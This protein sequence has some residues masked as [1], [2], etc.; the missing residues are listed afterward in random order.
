MLKQNI[1]FIENKAGSLQKATDI[2]KKEQIQIFGF[3]CFDA[4]E[5][6]LFR[7]VCSDAEKA[8]K[9]LSEN[10]YM[11]RISR[12]IAVD[13][14][15]RENGLDDVL[16]VLS[17]S[18]ISLNYIYP[19]CQRETMSPVMILHSEELTVTESVLKNRGFSLFE[20]V[21]EWN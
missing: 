6:A 16:Q 9:V 11:N 2:L 13:L 4:P 12:V 10:G 21:E 18:N 1:I 19:S 15:E 20:S 17:E 14:K 7:M 5:Y 8:E 3:A